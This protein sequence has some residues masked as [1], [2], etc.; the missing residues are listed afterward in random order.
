MDVFLD[1]EPINM[2]NI[3]DEV[4][5]ETLL[6]KFRPS[7]SAIGKRRKQLKTGIYYDTP[8]V[9]LY[10]QAKD[11]YCL[12]YFVSTI[13][14]CRSTAEYLAYEIFI[15]EVELDGERE[16]LE[17]IAGGLDFRKIVNDFLHNKKNGYQ[18]IDSK[19]HDLFNKLYDLGNQWIHPKKVKKGIRIEDEALTAI[20]VL[21]SLL[22]SLRD[23][24]NDYDISEGKFIKKPTARKKKRGISL[25][26]HR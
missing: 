10:D 9:A 7:L 22:S 4:A 2:G 6:E 5:A 14:V 16:I 18:I 20:E 13:M 21:G 26:T 12:G 19:T 3:S 1:L 23:V 8:S 11:L 17:A 24:M 25:G 15:E